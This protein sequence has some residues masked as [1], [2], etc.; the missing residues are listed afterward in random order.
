MDVD[1]HNL[2][3][4]N[5]DQFNM[6]MKK[7]EWFNLI[8]NHSVKLRTYRSFKFENDL[9]RYVSMF[10]IKPHRSNLA[11]FRLGVFPI[12]IET[13]RYLREKLEERICVICNTNNIE[14]EKHFY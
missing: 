7:R 5:M 11:Q 12:T 3:E 10:L 2:N 4:I 6:N 1:L 13:G 9:E 8:C 14:D